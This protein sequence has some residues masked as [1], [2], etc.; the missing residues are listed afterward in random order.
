MD[1]LDWDDLRIFLAVARNGR[2]IAAG[3]SAGLNHATIARRISRLEA[4]VGGKLFDR[5]PRGVTLTSS[6]LLLQGYAE[7]AERELEAANAALGEKGRLASGDVRL[8]T[9]EAFGTHLVAPAVP[10]FHQTY[11][12]IRLELVPESRI[13]SLAN[14]EADVAVMLD[15]PPRGR[16]VARRLIDY[17]LGLYASR[18][19]LARHTPIC[20][21]ADLAGHRVVAFIDQML[22]IPELRYTGEVSGNV[23]TIFRSS[24]VVAQENAVLAGLGLGMLHCF[25]AETQDGLVRVLSGEIEVRRSYWLVMHAERQQL[26]RVRAIVDFLDDLILIN[27]NRF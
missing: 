3:R 23:R 10:R 9:P 19:Y 15:R 5:S 21:P 14:R 12:D 27:R 8:A 2:M 16:L 22:D 1:K 4:S 17:R 26:P 11:P 25:W 18:D 20:V 24:S 7:R 6:G 13:V